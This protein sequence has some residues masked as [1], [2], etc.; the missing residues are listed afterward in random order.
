[1]KFYQRNFPWIINIM[2]KIVNALMQE[3][4]LRV[5]L[6][7]L[8]HTPDEGETIDYLLDEDEG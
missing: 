5:H 1:M 6:N 7:L 4:G 8:D 2:V 3:A